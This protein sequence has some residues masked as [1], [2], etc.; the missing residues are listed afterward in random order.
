M[1]QLENTGLV[2][3]YAVRRVCRQCMRQIQS[4]KPCMITTSSTA[5]SLRAFLEGGIGI[6]GCRTRDPCRL[7]D[8]QRA[9]QWVHLNLRFGRRVTVSKGARFRRVI[10]GST[11]RASSL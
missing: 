9:A 3:D 4:F 1:Q 10:G 5:I 7:T 11:K 2:R 8:S 6:E